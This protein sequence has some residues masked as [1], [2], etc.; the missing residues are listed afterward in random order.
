MKTED[1]CFAEWLEQTF[2]YGYGTGEE[3]F[4]TALVTFFGSLNDRRYDYKVLEEKLGPVAAWLL[5]NTFCANDVVDYGTS[6]RFGFLSTIGQRVQAYLRGK[7][8][9]QLNE[10]IGEMP[11]ELRQCTNH[12]CNC[13]GDMESGCTKN[14]FFSTYQPE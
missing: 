9:D 1:Q 2:P 6:P 11:D 3:H 5:I 10:M 14:P 8:A 4:L 12:Y 13:G 7:T